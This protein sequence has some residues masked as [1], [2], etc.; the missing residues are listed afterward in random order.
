VEKQYQQLIELGKYLVKYGYARGSAGNLSARLDD[1]NILVT[2]TNS[3]LGA[4]EPEELSLISIDGEHLAG[5]KPSKE[6][7]FHLSVYRQSTQSSYVIHLHSTYLTALSCVKNLDPKNVIKAFTPY[8]VMKV[9]DLPLVP[10]YKPGA[11][12]IAEEIEKLAGNHSAF[13]LANH[14]IVISGP[15]LWGT[16]YSF[17]EL[18]E[19]ARLYFLLKE[20]EV[21]YINETELQKLKKM[22]KNG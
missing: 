2:P 22:K 1:G 4:L 5:K 7:P 19:T 14:G 9:G 13:L 16:C 8:V 18:E 21:Q 15:E 10:Y 3:H 6:F 17:E 20:H 11:F 12:E